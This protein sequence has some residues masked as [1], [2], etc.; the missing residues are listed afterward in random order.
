MR[1]H[2]KW[3]L[4]VV[5][6][7]GLVL[8]IRF[9]IRSPEAIFTVTLQRLEVLVGT[10]AFAYLLVLSSVV[11]VKGWKSEP[12]TRDDVV[13]VQ[14]AT[15]MDD[16]E[17]PLKLALQRRPVWVVS[18][19]LVFTTLLPLGVALLSGSPGGPNP[20]QFWITFSVSEA[21]ALAGLVLAWRQR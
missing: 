18:V 4:F 15:A 20:R 11:I 9:F 7:P 5:S 17:R 14:V 19:V 8:C 3:L 2:L 12:S 21:I 6:L 16:R 1:K 10:L 13:D